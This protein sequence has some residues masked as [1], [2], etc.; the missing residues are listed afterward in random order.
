[1]RPATEADRPRIEAFLRANLARGMFPLSNLSRFGWEGDHPYAPSFWVAET[2]GAI[3][4]LLTVS[5]NG[6]VLPLLPSGGFGAA[7]EVL[8]G[9]DVTAIVGEAASARGLEARLPLGDAARTLDRDEPHFALELG[10]LRLPDRPGHLVP[11]SE[12]PA[13]TLAEWRDLYDREAL[14]APRPDGHARAEVAGWIAADSHRALIVDGAPVAMTGF[15]AWTPEAVQVGGVYTPVPLR[16]RGHAG[17]AVAL[18][19][20]EAREKGAKQ[21]FLFSASD[22]AARVYERLGF[23]R[24]GDWTLLLLKEPVRV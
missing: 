14:G 20:A 6:T 10:E 23:R 9:R 16:R 24:I 4:D 18:H 17:R 2:T 15:N 22:G 7:A 1:M 12:V 8:E 3:S 11:V 21:G 13:D 19:L 5:R